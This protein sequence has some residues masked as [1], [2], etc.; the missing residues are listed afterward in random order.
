[1]KINYL[2]YLFLF[3]F[4][5]NYVYSQESNLLKTNNHES[6][7]SP[8]ESPYDDEKPIYYNDRLIIKLTKSAVG[9]N[10]RMNGKIINSFNITGIDNLLMNY[11]VKSIIHKYPIYPKTPKTEKRQSLA[12]IYEVAFSSELQLNELINNL[13][14]TDGVEYAEL[15]PISYADVR[16]ND[17]NYSFWLEYNPNGITMEAEAAWD[18]HK[19]EDGDSVIVIG[20]SDSGTEWHHPDLLDNLFTNMGEDADGDG[21]VIELIDGVWQFDP[22]DENGIDDDGNGYRDDFI[23]WDF[24]RS[25]Q[26]GFDSNEVDVAHD[27]IHGTHVASLAAGVTDNG[28]GIASA[29]WNVKYL[30]VKGLGTDGVLYL[31]DFGVDIINCSW[32]QGES[33]YGREVFEYAQEQGCVVFAAAGNDNEHTV[34][35]PAGFP[36]VISV[37][38]LSNANNVIGWKAPFS[39]YGEFVDIAVKG[40]F[41]YA[42]VPG[43]SYAT[44]H[45]TSMASPVA[46]SAFA[47]L[48]SYKPDWS[49]DDLIR[50][51]LG[52]T[53]KVD[54]I[55]Y[56]YDFSLENLLG[57]GRVNMREMLETDNADIPHSLKLVIDDVQFQNSSD[58]YTYNPGDT[59]D[60]SFN[61]RNFN[62]LYGS[63]NLEYTFSSDNE[64]ISFLNGT[65]DIELMQDSTKEISGI[66]FVIS[67]EADTDIFTVNLEFSCDEGVLIG[68]HFEWNFVINDFDS[69]ELLAYCYRDYDFIQNKGPLK[70]DLATGAEI[71]HIKNDNSTGVSGGLWKD[72]IWY[73]NTY[74]VGSIS[75][76]SREDEYNEYHIENISENNL[77]KIDTS[78]GEKELICNTGE[79]V[80]GLTFDYTTGL[81][82]ITTAY[83]L[84]ILNP[85]TGDLRAIDYS[86]T[87]HFRNS[88]TSDKEGNFYFIDIFKDNFCKIDKNDGTVT[89]LFSIPYDL[90]GIQDITYDFNTDKIFL[91]VGGPD[92]KNFLG[93]IDLNKMKFGKIAQLP[94]NIELSAL[95]IA[96][97]YDDFY[98]E[99][100]YY[101]LKKVSLKPEFKWTAH[102]EANKYNLVISPNDDLSNPTIDTLINE[103]SYTLDSNLLPERR[104]FWKVTAM[105]DDEVIEESM[106]WY[107]DTEFICYEEPTDTDGDGFVNISNLCHLRWIGE[108]SEALTW[109]FEL[110]NDID[111]YETRYW[112]LDDHDNKPET[113]DS[114]MGWKP[115]GIFGNNAP[116]LA[117]T[118]EFDG[119]GH[120][121]KNLYYNHPIESSHGFF[122]SVSDGGFVHD[123]I[124]DSMCL[125][126]Y[127]ESGGLI[128]YLHS[129][130]DADVRV[131]NCNVTNFTGKNGFQKGALIGKITNNHKKVYILNCSSSSIM[132][133]DQQGEKGGLIGYVMARYDSIYIE[134][135]YSKSDIKGNF[136][137]AG[138]IGVIRSYGENGYVSVKNSYSESNV[139][140]N[141]PSGGFVGLLNP[142]QGK[143]LIENCYSRG[144]VTSDQIENGKFG[145]FAGQYRGDNNNGEV[146][147]KN[148]YS[149]TAVSMG[150][151]M[152]GLCAESNGTG[153]LDF[154][155][156]YWDTEAST[157]DISIG[158]EGKT[159]AEMKTDTT[160]NNW[161]FANIWDL[162][163]NIN[164]GYPHLL[165]MPIGNLMPPKLTYPDDDM[166]NIPVDTLVLKWNKVNNAKNYYIQI[167]EEDTFNDLIIS[168]TVSVDSLTVYNLIDGTLYH[169][170]V[171][172]VND[173]SISS[174]SH[175]NQ[176][177]TEFKE[178]EIELK[179]GI[180]FISSYIMPDSS[181][182]QKLFENINNEIIIVKNYE[183]E[184]YIP[185]LQ[186]NSIENWIFNTG[187]IAHSRSDTNL[188]I[189]GEQVIPEN[190]TFNLVSGWNLIPYLRKSNMSVNTVLN[191]IK[192]KINIVID[193]NNNIWIPDLNI[194]TIDEFIPGNAYLINIK[195]DT[196]FT[197]PPND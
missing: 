24:A 115:I 53:D 16:P 72:S 90:K 155:Y 65:D 66:S 89:E 50:Q 28:I 180:N 56:Y 103:Q 183:G 57:Y 7:I 77:V 193:E 10:N 169:W 171:K 100:P 184:I 124:L 188:T 81:Y 12:R 5:F 170:R 127:Q 122:G 129:Y 160:F 18:I 61:I 196:E 185:E 134:N 64:N 23:G 108:N 94:G 34:H 152:G 36:G 116:G 106:T 87:S 168:D 43:N 113:P 125:S 42:A 27:N 13:N 179:K 120:T 52:S 73:A 167:S 136:Y 96:H 92:F 165:N 37:A 60:I 112:N 191:D 54:T 59:I 161:D 82:Y 21:V 121:I 147:I 139:F 26:D 71:N 149:T 111:A 154:V 164:N 15:V 140:A 151:E 95:A 182:I 109:D 178:I 83:S 40:S 76:S 91:S 102:S 98:L 187:Y 19:G 126:G 194:N 118:G 84:Y 153:I 22:D 156:S 197:Y 55:S 6:I 159:T 39:N 2:L 85:E 158:G 4:L 25:Y 99:K 162:D 30:P 93:M 31:A 133:N 137:N 48:K 29:A 8:D 32:G 78:T 105:N 88:L 69:L 49:N 119:K 80:T 143:I 172:A 128:G 145:G 192:E 150:R 176:F 47:L 20:I 175:S 33:Q 58:I 79:A 181:D 63:S 1:M 104:Y 14:I 67:E 97:N 38:A 107:F 131:E 117:Y 114:A 17:H 190:Y 44:E 110:D 70:I 51:Y 135:C 74:L 144:E 163:A 177:T 35:Y 146:L 130:D 132:I 173:S 45:G 123:L 157:I 75:I 186:L 141:G 41:V 9:N 142:V 86:N 101:G 166:I 148:C 62:P 138:F 195:E 3:I 11:P 174:W 189:Y 46:A 68:D